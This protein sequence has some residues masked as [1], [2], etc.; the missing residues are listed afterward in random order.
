MVEKRSVCLEEGACK[1]AVWQ[2]RMHTLM[3]ATS[4]LKGDLS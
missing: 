3:H 2:T 1:E 4:R